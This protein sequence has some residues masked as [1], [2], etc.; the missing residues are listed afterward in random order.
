MTGCE[1]PTEP[2]TLL[3]SVHTLIRVHRRSFLQYVIQI[4][5]SPL[6]RHFIAAHTMLL[7]RVAPSCCTR[8]TRA[9]TAVIRASGPADNGTGIEEGKKVKVT[10]DVKV[11][12]APKQPT[13]I[14]LQ[15]KEGVVVKNVAF[16]KGEQLSPNLPY[17][18]QFDLEAEGAPAK[19]F[20]HLVSDGS[21]A[22]AGDMACWVAEVGCLF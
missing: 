5:L 13:G 21:D 16:Y 20:A 19:F 7:S 12:H 10:A 15:G 18:V 9:R 17:K 1:E 14:Q 6:S 2:Q 11:F 22:G 3:T 8:P 4:T